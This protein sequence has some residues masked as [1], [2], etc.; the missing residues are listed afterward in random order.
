MLMPQ[1]ETTVDMDGLPLRYRTLEIRFILDEF[2]FGHYRGK[3]DL[4]CVASIERFPTLKIRES[5]TY[6]Y[7]HTDDLNNERLTHR[8]SGKDIFYLPF[9]LYKKPTKLL[10]VRKLKFGCL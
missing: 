10:N 5:K 8:N 3:L 4:K 1:Q 7:V 9:C 6:I 2:R